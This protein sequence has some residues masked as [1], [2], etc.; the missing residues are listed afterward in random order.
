MAGLNLGAQPERVIL[1]GGGS[2]NFLGSANQVLF[3]Q[4]AQFAQITGSGSVPFT[5]AHFTASYATSPPVTMTI[6]GGAAQMIAIKPAVSYGSSPVLQGDNYAEL[7]RVAA[8]FGSD[9]SINGFNIDGRIN[10]KNPIYGA[11]GDGLT[12]DTAA[13]QAAYSAACSAAIAATSANANQAETLWFPAGVYIT[14]FSLISNC[15][16]PISWK[17][18]GEGACTIKAVSQGLF[19]IILHEANSYLNGI[20][21]QG[22]ILASSLAAGSGSSLN[23]G[24]NSQQYYDLK[25]AQ[26]GLSASGWNNAAPINGQTAL[27]VEGFLNYAGGASG[28]AYVLES[29]GDDLN[30]VCGG[31]PCSS[32]IQTLPS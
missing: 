27:S 23:W 10:V 20:T 19:P 26:S 6:G 7:T 15:S 18:E 32:A 22:S 21:T 14:S 29:N 9:A 13:I 30:G 25:D 17:C 24:A 28:N 5:G 8:T 3:N 31:N 12:D 4:G 2:N 11:K 16:Q 1:F